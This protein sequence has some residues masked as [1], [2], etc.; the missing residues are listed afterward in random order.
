MVLPIVASAIS[1]RCW[2][3]WGAMALPVVE[4]QP[5]AAL[6]MVGDERQTLAPLAFLA[7]ALVE[8]QAGPHYFGWSRGQGPHYLGWRRGHLGWRRG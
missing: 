5:L 1:H 4:D 8:E 7:L 6:P 2:G 3:G